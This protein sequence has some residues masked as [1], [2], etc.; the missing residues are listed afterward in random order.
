MDVLYVDILISEILTK[1]F[2][3]FIGYGTVKNEGSLIVWNM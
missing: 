2:T 1:R 3:L